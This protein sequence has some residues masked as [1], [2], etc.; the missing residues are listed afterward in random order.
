MGKTLTCLIVV[1]ASAC[2][3]SPARPARGTATV[4]GYL[5]LVP[6]EGIALPKKGS[7]SYGSRRLQ[8]VTL[9]DYAKPGFA[10]V[11][12]D[13]VPPEDSVELSI[14]SSRFGVRLEPERTVVGVGGALVVANRTSEPQLVSCPTTG[15][16]RRV[17][18]GAELTVRVSEPGQHDLFVL[19]EAGTK[20]S[21]FAAPGPY[22]VASER[23][24]YELCDVQPEEQTL[25]V[26]HTRFPPA[27]RPVHLL[28]DQSVRADVELKIEPSNEVAP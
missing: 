27:S 10:V 5:R 2:T 11:Y 21:V 16:L 8:G 3:A 23:G 6:H 18:P 20:S 14:R 26:W 25:F 1:L 13:G 9:V 4:W 22:A 15:V 12:V 17:E 7:G 19:N 28:V 24:R